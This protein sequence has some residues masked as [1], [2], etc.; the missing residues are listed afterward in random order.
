MTLTIPAPARPLPALAVPAVVPAEH[1]SALPVTVSVAVST[2]DLPVT[3]PP[4]VSVQVV[5]LLFAEAAVLSQTVR[6][7]PSPIARVVATTKSMVPGRFHMMVT[8]F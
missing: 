3:F 8:S 7:D 1:L 5:A 4:G 6:P 2:P